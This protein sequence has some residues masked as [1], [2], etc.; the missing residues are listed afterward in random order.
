LPIVPLT[1][2]SPG[3]PNDPLHAL[4]KKLNL[5]DQHIRWL[6]QHRKISN[7]GSI[8]AYLKKK[9]FCK[10]LL[11]QRNLS[12]VGKFKLTISPYSAQALNKIRTQIDV[13]QETIYKM[14]K[15][16]QFASLFVDLPDFQQ[17]SKKYS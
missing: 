13:F 14:H 2:Y 15:S 1:S 16:Q 7:H 12:Q 4:K 5:K 11:Q 10:N 8:K 17:L 9:S 6:K 3:T